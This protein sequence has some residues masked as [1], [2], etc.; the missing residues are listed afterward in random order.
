MVKT[1]GVRVREKFG[2]PHTLWHP[3]GKM[4]INHW[5]HDSG[6]GKPN[7]S[8]CP[9]VP[10]GQFR[11]ITT[12]CHSPHWRYVNATPWC[13]W[14]G[15]R[16]K[17]VWHFTTEYPGFPLSLCYQSID[18]ALKDPSLSRRH[19]WPRWKWWCPA[20]TNPGSLGEMPRPGK[21]NEGPT[22]NISGNHVTLCHL[23]RS[24]TV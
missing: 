20:V 22:M 5:K 18:A 8:W 24:V 10:C 14:V 11:P 7:Y 19:W 2:T 15:W 17:S 4:V 23:H 13:H 9:I 21:T 3:V 12:G 1:M 6:A 16:K